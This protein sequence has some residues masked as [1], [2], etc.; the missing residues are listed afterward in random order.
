MGVRSDKVPSKFSSFSLNVNGKN[1]D[2]NLPA[3]TTLAEALRNNLGL[4]GT[5]IGC[6]RA[7]CGSCTVILDNQAVFACTILA[8]ECAKKRIETIEGLESEGNLHPV[9]EAFIEYDAV[10][11]GIC[12][13]G[14]VMSAK[15]LLDTNSRPTESD[16]K[17]AI[18]GN[19]CRCGT[20]PNTIKA[21]IAAA[22]QMKGSK[23][24]A[25]A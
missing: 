16:I 19:L 24:R 6:N 17:M 14:M 1:F 18:S 12:I 10:Q 13:P 15:A 7:M 5:K 3:R 20:Y 11:C 22:E 9:Q 21:V 4:M 25:V 23:G 8:V 2:L